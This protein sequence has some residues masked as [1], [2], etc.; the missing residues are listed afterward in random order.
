LDNPFLQGISANRS[1]NRAKIVG[2]GELNPPDGIIGLRGYPG[3]SAE[4]L[5][6]KIRAQAADLNLNPNSPTLITDLEN[7]FADPVVGWAAS[8]IAQDFGIQL[9]YL[10]LMLKRGD[11]ENRVARPEWDAAHWDYWAQVRN[12]MFGGGLMGGKFGRKA[13]IAASNVLAAHGYSRVNLQCSPF[14][15]NIGLIGLA[16]LVDKA[17]RSALIFDFGQT[18]VKRAVVQLDEMGVKAVDPLASLPANCYVDGVNQLDSLARWQWMR[19]LIA[20]SWRPVDALGIALATYLQNGT[21]SANHYDCYGCLHELTDD[22]SSFMR[23]QLRDEYAIDVPIALFHD[24]A[25]AAA[26][27]AELNGVVI[28]VGTALGIGF[29]EEVTVQRKA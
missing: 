26:A 10:L 19:N 24:G 9:G 22:F 21:L 16:R 15:S 17:A 27:H 2:L 20:E 12:V 28:T 14:R 4:I 29:P 6:E 25:A 1:L 18:S 11:A 13:V 7:A 23:Q 3:L 8:E 5:H